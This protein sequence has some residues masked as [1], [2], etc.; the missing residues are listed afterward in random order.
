MMGVRG[1]RDLGERG[2]VVGRRGIC[3]G[4]GGV[5]RREALRTRRMNGSMPSRGGRCVWGL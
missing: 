4:I 3:S 5:N 2:E 1:G